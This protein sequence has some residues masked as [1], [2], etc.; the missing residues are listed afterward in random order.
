MVAVIGLTSE[1][2]TGLV[3]PPDQGRP[4]RLGQ[5]QH[6][7]TDGDF[8]DSGIGGQGRQPGQGRGR[9]GGAPES[10]QH[11]AFAVDGRATADFTAR[12]EKLTFKAPQLPIDLNATAAPETNAEHL[13][14]LMSG[15]LTSP[16]R[17]AQLILNLK[18]AGVDT[19]VEAGPKN[20]LTGL[21]RKILPEEPKE[22]F[23]NVENPEG[24]EKLAAA[25][26]G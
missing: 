7:G 22:R 1:K 16:V 4:H 14:Q 8:R 12:L 20:V 3:P 13:R 24:L 17:L 19:W 11:L 23:F 6:P 9:P 26:R 5:L 15:Q 21:V 18:A 25:V 2:L 10:L